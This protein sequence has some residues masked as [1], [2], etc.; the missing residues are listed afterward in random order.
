MAAIGESREWSWVVVGG[1]GWSRVAVPGRGWPWVVVGGRGRSWVVVG[2]GGWPWVAVGARGCPWVAAG[3]RGWML[4]I[5]VSSPGGQQLRTGTSPFW[6]A[7]ASPFR[8]FC[9]KSGPRPCLGVPPPHLS[10]PASRDPA[11]RISRRQHFTMRHL[12]RA[13]RCQMCPGSAYRC[14]AALNG[15]GAARHLDSISR[16]AMPIRDWDAIRARCRMASM[17]YRV[18]MRRLR[19]ISCYPRPATPGR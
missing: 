2:G 13:S 14:S 7:T 18:A 8:L 19:C 5:V 1:R 11:S 3:G 10:V 12:A 17:R 9:R 4:V 16:A 15:C 6:K